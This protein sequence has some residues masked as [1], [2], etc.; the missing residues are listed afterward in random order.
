MV[1]ISFMHDRFTALYG[2]RAVIYQS[3]GRINLI[4]E[5]TDYNEGFV[6]PAAI[7]M[8]IYVAISVR[9]DQEI[10]LFSE[11]YQQSYRETILGLKPANLQWPNYILGVVD[12]LIKRSLGVGGFNLVVDGDIP[13]GAGLSSS[14]ALECAVAYALNETFR[15]GLG[16]MELVQIAQKAEH[17]YAGVMCGIMDQFASVFGKKDQAMKLDCKTL[18]YRYVPVQLRGYEL[19][20]V[21]SHVKHELASSAYNERREACFQGLAW[22]REKY[23]QVESLRDVSQQ[24]LDQS[25][26]KRSEGVYQKCLYVIQENS[27][28][29]M[30]CK[31]LEQQELHLLGQCMFETHD[32]LSRQY[33]VSCE[34]L[35]FLVARAKESTH[36]IGARMMGGG[37]GGCTI[38]LLKQGTVTNFLSALK[39][40]YC[41]RFGIELT[42]YQVRIEEG[43]HC[44]SD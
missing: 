24:M 37:F 15:L 11:K 9:E 29:Q 27:R 42:A 19:L 30:A 38:N 10:H 43:S 32:G 40:L 14:A 20:L 21:N 3:P 2:G 33:E 36:V 17:Q 28:L 6:L 13:E 35:D 25:V 18:E 26:R 34:E 23:P 31:A 12:E 5:H 16:K 44:L 39:P 1:N 4:G 7:D 8:A 41:D 22:V